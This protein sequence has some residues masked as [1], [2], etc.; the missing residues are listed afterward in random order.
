MRLFRI[1][2]RKNWCSCTFT[3]NRCN[4]SVTILYVIR[5]QLQHLWLHVCMFIDANSSCN[6]PCSV[7]LCL[8]FA[9]VRFN[10]IL[11]VFL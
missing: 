1:L 5:Y 9:V 6:I 8:L 2:V 10:V 3:L 11:F 4:F 7:F